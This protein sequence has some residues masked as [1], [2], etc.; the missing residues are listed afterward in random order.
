MIERIGEQGGTGI[1]L[2]RGRFAQYPG[3]FYLSIPIPF[4]TWRVL[5]VR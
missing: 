1:V 3:A 2:R 5:V 4:T